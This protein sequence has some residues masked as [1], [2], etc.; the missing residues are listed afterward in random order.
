MPSFCEVTAVRSARNVLECFYHGVVL[1]ALGRPPGPQSFSRACF[2]LFSKVSPCLLQMPFPVYFLSLCL[3]YDGPLE[4]IG[5]SLSCQL[6]YSS[7]EV[8]ISTYISSV[9]WREGAPLFVSISSHDSLPFLNRSIP[10]GPRGI[11]KKG[12][13]FNNCL[14]R[15]SCLQFLG[16]KSIWKF[17]FQ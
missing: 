3:E 12:E 17:Q 11:R 4:G 15:V 8:N 13:I 9:K 16:D 14:F 7:L 5:K 6:P 10:V 1:T 2:A